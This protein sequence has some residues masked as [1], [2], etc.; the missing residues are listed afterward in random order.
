M[1]ISR[2]RV[3]F[4]AIVPRLN[5]IASLG[6]FKSRYGISHFVTVLYL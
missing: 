1:R 2:L 6:R 4:V 3:H 5:G